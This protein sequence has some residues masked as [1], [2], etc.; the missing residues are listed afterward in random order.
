MEETNV[1]MVQEPVQ[2]LLNVEQVAEMLNCSTRTVRRLAETGKMP[3]SL[4]LGALLRWKR[5]AIQEW[6]EAGCPAM[7]TPSKLKN[8]R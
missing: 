5:V 4:K 8:R 6:I 7:R 1:M 3:R 2:L